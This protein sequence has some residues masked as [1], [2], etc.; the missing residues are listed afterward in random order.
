MAEVPRPVG[1]RNASPTPAEAWAPAPVHVPAGAQ[2]PLV[3]AGLPVLQALDVGGDGRASGRVQAVLGEERPEFGEGGVLELLEP[4]GQQVAD[5]VRGLLG[6]AV[7]ERLEHEHAVAELALLAD[8]TRVGEQV[9]A[10]V[11]AVREGVAQHPQRSRAG[12]GGRHLGLRG[13]LDEARR[14][15]RAAHLAAHLDVLHG[16]GDPAGVDVGQLP[17]RLPQQVLGTPREPFPP[18]LRHGRNGAGPQVGQAGLHG[19]GRLRDLGAQV[20]RHERAQPLQVD[21]AAFAVLRALEQLEEVV[22]E[23]ED[24]HVPVGDQRQVLR[25]GVGVGVGA[26]QRVV[27]GVEVGGVPDAGAFQHPGVGGPPPRVL[28][29]R[30]QVGVQPRRMRHV[31]VRQ[32]ERL[33]TRHH[34]H[35]PS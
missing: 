1:C 23:E 18:V 5:G 12:H 3:P 25:G 34:V 11:H 22:V 32:L 9:V 27:V 8:L 14:P 33:C 4:G 19:I 17:H 35:E 6:R 7:E 30:L 21:T 28:P 10:Q 24:P 13:A 2:V 16:V 31:E 20:H 15:G 29:R 26:Q